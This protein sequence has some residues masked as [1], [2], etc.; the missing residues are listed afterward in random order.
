[1]PVFSRH[2]LFGSLLNV[3]GC[4]GLSST[5]NRR[6]FCNSPTLLVWIRCTARLGFCTGCDG[7]GPLYV[8]DSWSGCA[9]VKLS[10]RNAR[11]LVR[12]RL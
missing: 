11:V 2:L 10:A 12:R 9:I 1:L 7:C 5:S 4:Q 3:I 6:R 8:G